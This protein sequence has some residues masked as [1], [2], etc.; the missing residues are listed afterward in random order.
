MNPSCFSVADPANWKHEEWARHGYLF[1]GGSTTKTGN[2]II[3][4]THPTD[5]LHQ[6]SFSGGTIIRCIDSIPISWLPIQLSPILTR[7]SA[8]IDFTFAI[9]DSQMK[10][11]NNREFQPPAP[12]AREISKTR[13]YIVETFMTAQIKLNCTHSLFR[14]QCQTIY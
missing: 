11:I 9:V 12:K 10:I 13:W 8:I 2:W 1:R 14:S 3:L 7:D 4:S 6:A 5:R